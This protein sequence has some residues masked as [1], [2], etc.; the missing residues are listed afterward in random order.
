MR[1]LRRRYAVKVSFM[2]AARLLSQVYVM[3][4]YLRIRKPHNKC[5][6]LGRTF[7]AAH[8]PQK[9]SVSKPFKRSHDTTGLYT[10]VLR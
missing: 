10:T 9:F 4:Y 2:R 3:C 8:G 5:A 1:L 7:S 6:I